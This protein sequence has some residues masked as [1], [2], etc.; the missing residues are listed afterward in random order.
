MPVTTAAAAALSGG[1]R[2]A[3]A[4]IR[5]HENDREKKAHMGRTSHTF[6]RVAA[7]V[8]VLLG[9][10]A[11]GCAVTSR[12]VPVEE[13]RVV[14]KAVLPQGSFVLVHRIW[15]ENWHVQMY[16]PWYDTYEQAVDALR[17]QAA[18]RGADAVTNV[19][20][21][22]A[23]AWT[24]VPK[25]FCHGDAVKLTPDGLRRVAEAAAN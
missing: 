14:D 23:P 17:E 25:V 10:V 13:V 9:L 4:A 2:I 11:A 6:G 12:T 20:C 19:A 22:P 16:M 5:R 3:R 8:V 21:I 24:R 15:I 7:G 1:A 18:S